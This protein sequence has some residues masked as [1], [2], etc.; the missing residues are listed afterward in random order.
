MLDEKNAY[1]NKSMDEAQHRLDSLSDN[2]NNVKKELYLSLRYL[3]NLSLKVLP[4]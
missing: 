2:I 3:M 1:L 4:Q